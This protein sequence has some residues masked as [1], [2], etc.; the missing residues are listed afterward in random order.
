MRACPFCGMRG[1]HGD[2]TCVGC[3]HR[4]E[5]QVDDT[6][7]ARIVW[8]QPARERVALTDHERAVSAKLLLSVF[9]DD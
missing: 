5:R 8:S 2:G 3:G 6:P 7:E 1:R 9:G 4:M